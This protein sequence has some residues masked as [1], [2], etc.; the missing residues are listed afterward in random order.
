MMS[1]HGRPIRFLVLVLA[2]WF[3]LRVIVLWLE[4]GSL[5]EA[6]REAVPEPI[7]PLIAS[8]YAPAADRPGN[9]VTATSKPGPPTPLRQIA[10]AATRAPLG[11]PNDAARDSSPRRALFGLLARSE[12]G[13]VVPVERSQPA[14]EQ[15]VQVQPQAALLNAT[16]RNRW[17]ASSWMI[18]RSGVGLSSGADA[19]QLGGTQAGVRL[20]YA[21]GRRVALTGR[22]AAPAHGIGREASLGIAYQP[23]GLPLRIIAEQRVAL[24]KGQGGPSVTLAGGGVIALPG[25]FDLTGYAQGGAVVRG[26][27]DHFVDGSARVVRP[28]ASL[29]GLEFDLGLGAWGGAQRGAARLDLGPS[30]SAVLPMTDRAVRVSLDWRQ[31]VGGSAR[32]GSGPALSIGSDF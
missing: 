30:V 2:G 3:S 22:L 27:L 14:A 8:R 19:P 10:G 16:S 7:A 20:D 26:R 31:R 18:A 13:P 32:P 17:S 21:I 15:P 11:Q 23:R 12:F 1:L 29:G 6:V 24:D 9:P 25:R 28:I 4:T 5:P